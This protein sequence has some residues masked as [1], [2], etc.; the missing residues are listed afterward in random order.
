MI[1]I[2]YKVQLLS[3]MI[4]IASIEPLHIITGVVAF[5]LIAII[6]FYVARAMKGK[7]E[8]ELQKN[9]FNSGEEIVGRVTLTAKKS[10]NMNRMY[11]S[12]I[13]HEIIERRDSDGNKKLAVMRFTAMKSIFLRPKWC[14]REHMRPLISPSVLPEPPLL[15]PVRQPKRWPMW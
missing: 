8:I 2:P 5:I 9:G 3:I 11:V 13:G 1:D 10:L 6:T 7:L 15:Q 14:L 12:L 4:P